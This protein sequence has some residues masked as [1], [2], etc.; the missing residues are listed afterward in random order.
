VPHAHTRQPDEVHK[1]PGGSGPGF[2][3]GIQ[4]G[5]RVHR[6][7]PGHDVVLTLKHDIIACQTM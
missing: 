5:R 6:G 1:Q 3:E 7:H 2:R 4:N